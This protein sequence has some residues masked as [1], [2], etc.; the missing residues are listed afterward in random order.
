[1]SSK[2]IPDKSRRVVTTLVRETSASTVLD[3][4]LSILNNE[5]QRYRVKSNQ[6]FGLDV[7]EAKILRTYVQSLVDLSREQRAQEVHDGFQAELEA[8][9][10]EELIEFYQQKVLESK[11]P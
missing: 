4:A 5:V 9:K 3:D 10:P 8:M 2:L 11:K 6:G 1:M 7:E